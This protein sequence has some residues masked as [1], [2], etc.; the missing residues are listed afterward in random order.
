MLS[1]PQSLQHIASMIRSIASGPFTL[2]MTKHAKR[3]MLER[4][5][6]Y[7]DIKTVLKHCIV[8]KEDLEKGEWVFNAQGTNIDGETI[9]FVVVPYEKEIK[10]KVISSWKPKR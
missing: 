9:V 2:K 7:S 4:D 6:N 10:I 3:Q 5:I 8:T 1:N